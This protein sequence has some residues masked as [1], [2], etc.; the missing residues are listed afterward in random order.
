MKK[1]FLSTLIVVLVFVCTISLVSCKKQCETCSFGEWQTVTEPTCTVE[2]EKVRTCTVC[3]TE[4]RQPIEKLEHEV[5]FKETKSAPTCTAKGVDLWACKNCDYTQEKSI[6]AKGHKYGSWTET[7][8]ATCSQEGVKTKTCSVCSKT[9]TS[10]ISK[11]AH[12]YTEKITQAA[13]CVK[14]G[15]KTKTCSGC[16]HSIT[17]TIAKTNSHSTGWGKCSSCGEVITTLRSTAQ[18]IGE[19]TSKGVDYLSESLTNVK[20][21][22]RSSSYRGTSSAVLNLIYA[23]NMGFVNAVEACGNYAEFKERKGY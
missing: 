4:E 12:S 9:E 11:T 8:A 7:V 6:N 10:T 17:S 16:G 14:N 13:T 5:S 19:N 1:L 18:S 2:G 15:V 21:A 22:L 23:K 3:E 20:S